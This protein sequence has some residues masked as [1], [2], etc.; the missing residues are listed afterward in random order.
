M[1]RPTSCAL[2]ASGRSH[3]AG[4]SAGCLLV[5]VG[6]GKLPQK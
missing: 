2:L 5:L 6:E 3:E 1:Y 4:G